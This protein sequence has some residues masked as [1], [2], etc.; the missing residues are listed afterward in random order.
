MGTL[1][2]QLGIQQAKWKSNVLFLAYSKTLLF[3][4]ALEYAIRKVQGNG[5]GLELKGTHQLLVYSDISGENI[6]TI[7]KKHKRLLDA[8]REAGL[9]VKPDKLSTGSRLVTKMQA[10]ITIYC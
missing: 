5:E 3:T 7:R 6:N 2:F 8:S 4:F 9:E 10:K 1:R